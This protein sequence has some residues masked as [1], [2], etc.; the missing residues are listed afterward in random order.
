MQPVYPEFI[1]FLK[2]HG[3]DTS[4]FQEGKLWLDNNIVKAFI[5]GGA[6]SLPI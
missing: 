2:S 6:S 1:K 4:W 5:A 3:C